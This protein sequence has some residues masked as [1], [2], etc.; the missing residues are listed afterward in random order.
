[1]LKIDLALKRNQGNSLK[2]KTALIGFWSGRSC[3]PSLE[4]VSALGKIPLH[5]PQI[6]AHG[7]RGT[8][9]VGL[10]GRISFTQF[11]C[12][13]EKFT[14]LATSVAELQNIQVV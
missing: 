12:C 11:M 3:F 6:F 14:S 10:E 4:I 13:P 8:Q 1:M 5:A 7:Y 2:R 9:A